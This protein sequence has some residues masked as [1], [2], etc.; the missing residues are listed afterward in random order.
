MIDHTGLSVSDFARSKAF[1]LAAL[2]PIGYRMLM[3]LK[4]ED[5]GGFAGAGFGV[6]P[7]PDFWIGKGKPNDPPIHIA[8]RVA[9][10]GLVDKFYEA[11]I[12]AGGRDN[13]PPGMRPHYHANYYGA[14][15]LDPDGHNIEA[16]CHDAA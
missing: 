1:Y 3:E 12:A 6:P 5:T 14:F 9:N 15:V 13:G 2:E 16:V 10:R 8:F 4:P 7:K 11:A